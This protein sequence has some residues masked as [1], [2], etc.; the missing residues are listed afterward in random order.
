M[1]I[2]SRL[3]HTSHRDLLL[4]CH[5]CK[6][7]DRSSSSLQH[8]AHPTFVPTWSATMCEFWQPARRWSVTAQSQNFQSQS[9]QAQDQVS[10]AAGNGEQCFANWRNARVLS[11]RSIA[12]EACQNSQG[13]PDRRAVR[14]IVVGIGIKNQQCRHQIRPCWCLL[15]LCPGNDEKPIG[16]LR[17][18][19]NIPD[20]LSK[21][22]LTKLRNMH[23]EPA[24]EVATVEL[25]QPPTARRHW[26]H[27]LLPK[28]SFYD[29][30][31]SGCTTS[32]CLLSVGSHTGQCQR[33][34]SHRRP[35]CNCTWHEA[36]NCCRNPRAT[37]RTNK[38]H[39]DPSHQ[40]NEDRHFQSVYR[41][42]Q[43]MS[44]LTTDL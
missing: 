1:S 7:L 34:F 40:N 2:P 11:R 42:P 22:K 35:K 30:G 32:C 19:Q 4:T 23:Y 29:D 18:Q 9:Y 37:G 43:K 41:Q 3:C 21:N 20:V 38:S 31:S 25:A 14:T 10:D 13:G 27:C 39:F 6:N 16:K 36:P 8:R 28:R 33:P 44:S 26:N 17:E 24:A 15:E 12:F 5:T